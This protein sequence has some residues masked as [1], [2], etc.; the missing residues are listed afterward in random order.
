MAHFFSGQETPA[1]GSVLYVLLVECECR[2][3]FG[4]LVTEV[5]AVAGVELWIEFY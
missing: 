5:E 1:Q 2:D 3:R 4:K